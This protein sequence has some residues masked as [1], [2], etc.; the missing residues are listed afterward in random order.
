MAASFFIANNYN[1]QAV[2]APN[3]VEEPID[4][5]NNPMGEATGVMPGRVVWAWN[6]DATSEDIAIVPGDSWWDYKN[7]DTTIIRNMVTNSLQLLTQTE[8]H[9]EAWHLIFSNHNQKKHGEDRGYHDD[10][11]IFVKVNQGTAG[12][13]AGGLPEF[14]WP[15]SG[16]LDAIESWH[17]N[18]FG[19]AETGPFVV[20]N[21]L[22]QLVNVAG[23]PQE[24][25]F[26]GD[27]MAIIFKHN[28]D[29]WHGEFPNVKYIDKRPENHQRTLITEAGQP[30]MFYS[31]NGTILGHENES[32]F[33]EMEEA[34]YLINVA[35]FKPHKRAGITLTAKN[36]FGSITR[37]GAEHLHPSLISTSDQGGVP[38]N[39]GYKKYR[40][41]V[42]IMGH[43]YLGQNTMLFVLEALFGGSEDEVKKPIKY[44]S[45]PFNG[46]W[47]NS[48]FMS[49]DQVAL[50]SVAYDFLR[51]E[52]D[53]EK[54]PGLNGSYPDYPNWEGVDDYLHQAA[55]PDNWPEGIT[56]N[57][58][59]SG[60]LTSLGIHEHWNNPIDKQYSRNL[61]LDTGIEL[62]Q[63]DGFA[64]IEVSVN[65]INNDPLT[66]NAYPNPLRDQARVSFHLDTPGN[67]SFQLFDMQGRNVAIIE[68]SYR[69][70]GTQEI[71]WKA[72]DYGL[73]PGFYI[74]QIR[75]SGLKNIVQ[76]QKIQLLD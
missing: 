46:D 54:N 55:D 56:Y 4:G 31:D 26:V 66:M 41:T 39:S 11:K 35:T 71:Q 49:L 27:P 59:G 5:A 52:F 43:K 36:H 3:T 9:A 60:V 29:V 64:N 61:G 37:D 51:T 13:L 42:D 76:N 20:L 65:E 38:H 19:A 33:I 53:G 28:F 58:D 47:C 7:N 63:T 14:G 12:W 57:P 10:E 24:Q 6:P 16:G 17:K 74:M 50:E 72:S 22:R 62:I 75:V 69:G 2:A 18:H 48:I 25:I 32:F 45:D 67:V 40:V 44:F 1:Q 73:K 23:V 34:D 68:N 21:I 30:S 70:S 15:E 8:D